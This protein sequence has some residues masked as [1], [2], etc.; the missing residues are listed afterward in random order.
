MKYVIKIFFIIVCSTTVVDAH[1]TNKVRLEVEKEVCTHPKR[2]GMFTSCRGKNLKIPGVKCYGSESLTML[3]ENVHIG[4]FSQR[5]KPEM[6]VPT[7]GCESH[8]NNW[9]GYVMF[10][11]YGNKWTF[12]H[13]EGGSLGKDCRKVTLSNG[14]DGLICEWYFMNQGCQQNGIELYAM[15]NGAFH[16][17]KR[18]YESDAECAANGIIS[19]WEKDYVNTLIDTWYIEKGKLVIKTERHKKLV[20]PLKKYGIGS[21]SSKADCYTNYTVSRQKEGT[22]Y[23]ILGKKPCKIVYD[24]QKKERYNNCKKLT[25]SKG[26]RIY[27][28]QRMD[29]CKTVQEVRDAI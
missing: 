27:C 23:T 18:L 28:T 12:F 22:V 6:Y 1:I 15:K 17:V 13:Y 8:V 14:K 10:R 20:I 19:D 11:K 25:N 7:E 9:G 3:F 24:A 16:A 26:I 4:Y 5:N 2:H 21:T 29:V